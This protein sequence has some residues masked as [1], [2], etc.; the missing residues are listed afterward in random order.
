MIQRKERYLQVINYLKEY[1]KLR[2]RTVYN[3][4]GA[5][6]Y[7]TIIWV[8]DVPDC[9][10]INSPIKVNNRDADFLLSLV[11]PIEPLEPTFPIPAENLNSWIDESTLRNHEDTPILL[12]F[13]EEE[14]MSDDF[15]YEDIIALFEEYLEQKWNHWA[16]AYKKY[17]PIK[18]EYDLKKEL[19]FKLF[20]AYNKV[21]NFPEAFELVV[22]VGLFKYCSKK[23]Q[24]INRHIVNFKLDIEFLKGKITLFLRGDENSLSIETEMLSPLVEEGIIVSEA[25]NHLKNNIVQ[26]ELFESISSIQ[27]DEALSGFSTL[28]SANAVFNSSITKPAKFSTTPTVTLSPAIILREKSQKGYAQVYEQIFSGIK[29]GDADKIPLLDAFIG[30]ETPT[31]RGNSS[32]NTS[33][34]LGAK[35][36]QEIVFP[37]K[38]NEEQV[39]IIQQTR[40]KNRVLV[41]GPPGTGKSH[42]IANL[43]CNLLGEGKSVLVTAHTNRALEVLINHIPESFH[44]LV[45]FLLE[46]GTKGETTLSK[47]IKGLQDSLNDASKNQL[48]VKIESSRIELDRLKRRK[49]DL[50]NKLLAIIE[51]DTRKIG[52]AGY[53]EQSLLEHTKKI[54]SDKLI[55]GCWEDEIKEL[56]K[57]ISL[58]ADLLAYKTL[59]QTIANFSKNPEHFFIPQKEDLISIDNYRLL[60]NKFSTYQKE[61]PKIKRTEVIK[62]PPNSINLLKQLFDLISQKA[63][64]FASDEYYARSYKQLIVGKNAKWVYLFNS[65]DELLKKPMQAFFEFK[66]YKLKFY[67]KRWAAC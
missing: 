27:L 3:I 40:V 32:D 61:F 18:A 63:K 22:G 33:L 48:K 21:K 23:Q 16:I 12:P 7:K 25:S 35:T 43:I 14:E 49:A 60:R 42:T 36:S 58:V 54:K 5:T 29:T 67:W 51:S 50:N 24:F 30:I 34:Y 52:I 57:T 4:E 66:I 55:H 11:R 28:L 41:Q 2:E 20:E 39:K 26:Q 10:G 53:G 19:Y 31:V 56:P 62:I 65:C 8:D 37:K 17:L 46:I 47:S 44:Q 64:I 13:D 59:T 45:I 38:Y 1:S 15:D 6:K 9:D